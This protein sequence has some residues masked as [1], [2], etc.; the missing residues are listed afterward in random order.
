VRFWNPGFVVRDY[1]GMLA[2]T[3]RIAGKG[4]G[5]NE[6]VALRWWLKLLSMSQDRLIKIVVC[7][8]AS[9]LW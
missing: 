2:A 3:R 5:G 8:I 6:A 7:M 1:L 4:I 9:F